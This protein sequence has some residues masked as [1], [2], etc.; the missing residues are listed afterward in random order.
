MIFSV[1]SETN[2]DSCDLQV[3]VKIV[4]N[5]RLLAM[6]DL[7]STGRLFTYS[8]KNITFKLGNLA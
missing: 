8:I 5:L 2:Y 6:M 7:D 4:K 1:N 3:E